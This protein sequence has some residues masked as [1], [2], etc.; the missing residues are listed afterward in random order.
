MKSLSEKACKSQYF[1]VS[2]G[3]GD[4]CS[5]IELV[6]ANDV[7]EEKGGQR[8]ESSAGGWEGSGTKLK[9]YSEIRAHQL[10]LKTRAGAE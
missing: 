6:T 10:E 3:H 4:K 9:D 5:V 2:C 8:A 1:K 7:S